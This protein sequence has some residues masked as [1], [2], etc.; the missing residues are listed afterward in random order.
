MKTIVSISKIFLWAITLML[1]ATL[2]FLVYYHCAGMPQNDLAN[3]I[4]RFGNQ[5]FAQIVIFSL[6]LITIALRHFPTKDLHD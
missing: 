1:F 5:Y 4:T 3:I 2:T 6:A